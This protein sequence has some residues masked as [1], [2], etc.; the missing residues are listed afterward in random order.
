MYRSALVLPSDSYRR[1]LPACRDARHRRIAFVF[2]E[3]AGGK[4]LVA[5]VT[6][7]LLESAPAMP[8]AGRCG[9]ATAS[10]L[11]RHRCSGAPRQGRLRPARA[12]RPT[13]TAPGSGTIRQGPLKNDA[14]MR[15]KVVGAHQALLVR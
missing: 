1:S 14:S 15:L 7:G 8:R 13:R 9:R 11:P 5:P 12:G 4:P 3:A 2:A 10:I 6:E